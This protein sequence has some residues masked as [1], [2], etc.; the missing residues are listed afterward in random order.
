MAHEVLNIHSETPEFRKLNKLAYEISNG[1]VVLFPMDTGF[2]LCCDLGNKK[3]IKRIRQMRD[4]PDDQSLTFLCASL[5]KISEFAKVS[6]D[7]YKTLKSLIPG[8][9]TFI[10]PASKLVPSF[11]Q[12]KK[13]STAGIRVPDSPL[14][15]GLIECLEHPLI[16][17]SAKVDNDSYQTP[18]EIIDHYIKIVDYVVETD[19][20]NFTGEST[21][22]DMTEE[23]S[24]EIVREGA[25]LEKLKEMLV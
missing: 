12:N 22:V 19:T 14:A 11:A 16:A 8:P 9:Y 2:S 18:Q 6:N 17:I 10:L 15:K 21:V 24:Y 1:A 13:R 7:A 20:Y 3:A 4:L 5:N 23:G 25:G